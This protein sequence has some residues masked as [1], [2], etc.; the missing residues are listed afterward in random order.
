M[1][2]VRAESHAA[3]TVTF[4]EDPPLGSPPPIS[5][6]P[7]RCDITVTLTHP[8]VADRVQV[9]VSLPLERGQWNGRFQGTGGSAYRPGA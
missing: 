8:G 5:D 9:K 1:V 7:A 2:A 4:P 3:G 6:V